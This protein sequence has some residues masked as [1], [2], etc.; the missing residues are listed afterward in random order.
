VNVALF[1]RFY[2]CP[3]Y[4][5]SLLESLFCE[6]RFCFAIEDFFR[7]RCEEIVDGIDDEIGVLALIYLISKYD[8]GFPPTSCPCLV[9]YVA[10]HFS[11]LMRR[12]PDDRSSHAVA[13]FA[14]N[15]SACSSTV[16]VAF[17]CLSGG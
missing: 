6:V 10:V 15:T 8:H 5:G 11:A 7:G 9:A 3:D 12:R 16:R 13:Q 14:D 1:R 2:G 17:S 4:L